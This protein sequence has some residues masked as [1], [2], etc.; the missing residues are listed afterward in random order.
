MSLEEVLE[1][2]FGGPEPEPDPKD[3]EPRVGEDVRVMHAEPIWE[4]WIECRG[5]TC[6]GPNNR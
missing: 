5:I 6:T 3:A 2:I 4:W 1:C